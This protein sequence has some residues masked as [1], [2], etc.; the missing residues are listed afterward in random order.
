MASRATAEKWLTE[1]TH[2]PTASGVEDA[3]AA[4]VIRWVARREDLTDVL[5]ALVRP[6]DVVLTLGAG[7]ITA[8]AG[9]VFDRLAGAAA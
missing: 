5:L 9:E 2:L 3:V 8:V 6:G 1:L 4:W 7:D